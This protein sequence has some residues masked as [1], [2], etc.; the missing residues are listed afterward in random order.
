M[1]QF[2]DRNMKAFKGRRIMGKDAVE[3]KKISGQDGVKDQKF[4]GR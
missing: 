1:F 3:T 2:A 4:D